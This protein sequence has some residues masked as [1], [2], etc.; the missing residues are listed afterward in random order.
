MAGRRAGELFGT[1]PSKIIGKVRTEVLVTLSQ[2][3]EEPEAFLSLVGG[4]DL[5]EPAHVV[6][7]VEI[8]H[9][10]R[11]VVWSSV[12]I[13][14]DDAVTGRLVLLRDV[15]REVSAERARRHLVQRIEQLTPVD[16]LTG[17]ANRR[18]FSEEH[19]REHA[20]AMR[21]WDSYAVMRVD[22]DGMSEINEAFGVPIGDLV[23]ERVAELLRTGRRD[24]DV[25]ARLVNDEYAILLPGADAVA[26][27]AVADRI[28]ATIGDAV[29]E[30][31]DGPQLTLSIGVAVC[32]PPTGETSVD[33][34]RRGGDALARARERGKSEIE[35]DILAEEPKDSVR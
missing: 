33:V 30:D 8:R 12:P 13:K 32:V 26:A 3:C 29:A 20:R 2:A 9:P 34:M 17:L 11:V 35:V 27:R 4:S 1:E 10:R 21:A 22:V 14:R 16:A 7:E 24:Y 5:T 19:M 23:L 28:Q 18:H 15:T 25:V 6:G 31:P